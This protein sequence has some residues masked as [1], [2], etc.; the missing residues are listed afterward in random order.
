VSQQVELACRAADRGS[1]DRAVAVCLQVDGAR[2]EY[3]A[4]RSI[5]GS[6]YRQVGRHDLAGPFDAAGLAAEVQDPVGLSMCLLGLAADAVGAGDAAGARAALGRAEEGLAAVRAW[7]WASRWIDPWLTHAW[8][9][10]EVHLLEGDAA[11]AAAVLEPFADVRPRA[12]PGTRWPHERA[13]TLLFLGVAQRCAGDPGAA[14][15]RLR[16]A[17]GISAEEGLS[18]LLVPA[19]EQL[20]QLDPAAAQPF[21]AACARARTV[22]EA[23][24]PPGL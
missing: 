9:R 12:T 18:P 16:A 4:C 20:S 24:R 1:F 19:F 3:A 15:P 2:T 23:H 17:V 11:G 22:L 6:V 21:S 7:H 13:K 10:A 8:V 14:V 5:L